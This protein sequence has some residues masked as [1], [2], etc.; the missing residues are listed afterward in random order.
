MHHHS[1]KYRK[2][3]AFGLISAILAPDLASA[4]ACGCGVFNVGL[5]GLPVTGTTDQY[6]LQYSFMNQNENQSGTSSAPA[7]LNPDKQ[8]R[9]DYYTLFGQHM[10][11]RDWG[12]MA[13]APYWKRHFSTDI[14]GTPGITD[15]ATGVIPGVQSANVSALSDIRVM[16]MYTG[17]SPDMSTGLTFGLKLP[18]GPYNASPLLDRDTEPGTGTTDLLL[19]GYKMGNIANNWSWYLQ[20]IWRHALDHREGYKPGD[21]LNLVGGLSYGGIEKSTQIVPLLQ[22]NVMARAHD[23]GGGDAQYGNANS[24]YKNIYITPGMLVDLAEHWQLNSSLYLP[25][26]RNVNGYQLVPHWMAN[27]GI[28]YM[29]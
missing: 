25:V 18:T 2:A 10:F 16:G 11:N 4:C 29:F 22:V 14:N 1:Y 21:S 6:S 27:A 15:Q 26:S 13:E 12:I 20:G 19:G 23:Q 8:I 9:T 7:S 5:P 28:T 17:L 24:G 3:I